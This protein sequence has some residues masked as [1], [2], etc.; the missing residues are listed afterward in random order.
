MQLTPEFLPVGSIVEYNY[1]NELG[2][3][4]VVVYGTHPPAPRKQPLLDGKWPV[5]I[6]V[7]GTTYIQH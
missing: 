1:N 7:D 6:W 2:K 3:M 5:D 4:P